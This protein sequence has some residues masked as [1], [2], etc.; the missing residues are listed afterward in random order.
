MKRRSFLIA[1][2]A[3]FASATASIKPQRRF[4][5]NTNDKCKFAIVRSNGRN[6]HIPLEKGEYSEEE[7]V[8]AFKRMNPHEEA[9]IYHIRNLNGESNIFITNDPTCKLVDRS[10]MHMVRGYR[11]NNFVA[12]EYPD[13]PPEMLNEVSKMF[14]H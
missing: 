13:I 8:K 14:Q 4:Y 6:S 9:Y 3:C 1:S 5:L 12:D 2:L 11:I 10:S 7:V